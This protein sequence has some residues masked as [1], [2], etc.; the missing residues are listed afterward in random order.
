MQGLEGENFYSVSWLLSIIDLSSLQRVIE[1][2]LCG[3]WRGLRSC[4]FSPSRLRAVPGLRGDSFIPENASNPTFEKLRD[5]VRENYAGNGKE[6]QYARIII[7]YALY[8]V[9]TLTGFCTTVQKRG[10]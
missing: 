3:L 5:N 10:T 4:P 7:I 2:Q 1:L 6:S 9:L 8:A